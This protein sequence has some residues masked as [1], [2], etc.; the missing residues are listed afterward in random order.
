[1]KVFNLPDLG[2][3]L[4]EAEVVE[5]QVAEGEHVT[6][7][8]I[9]LAV[10]TAK[11]IV[12]I[13]SPQTGRV[14]KLL[15]KTGDLVKTGSA[16]LVYAESLEEDCLQANKNDQ[17]AIVGDLPHA[18]LS[19]QDNF[20]VTSQ[21]AYT[22][23]NSY[24]DHSV[25]ALA[26]HLNIDISTVKA[27]ADQLD[28]KDILQ[29]HQQ[30]NQFGKPEKLSGVRRSM[31][32]NMARVHQEVPQ[33]SLLDDADI[34]H[35]SDS[36]DMSLRL[37]KALQAGCEAV[38]DMNAW[39]QHTTQS[40][41]LLRQIDVGVAVDSPQGLFVP[42]MRDIA[43]RSQ[44][45]LRQ[46]LNQ[47]KQAVH[48]RTIPAQEMQGATIML[49]NFGNLGGRYATP[50]LMPPCVAIL[51]AGKIQRDAIAVDEHIC[52][53]RRLPL[54]LSFDHRVVTGAEASRFLLAVINSLQ[55]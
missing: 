22:P 38:P 17:G 1:M 10:E 44:E 49:S 54:S 12:D 25:Q 46:G 8:Q 11:A 35:W 4:P 13:P 40:R 51:G 26:Q 29:A 28:S 55:H 42:V 48:Q 20:I 45:D 14:E 7:D 21:H 53:H 27:S 19:T 43:S 30:H 32:M 9:I 33:V 5:W 16:L 37:L 3:G 47:L 41:Q 50:M 39:Y 52:I 18:N 2:E 34:Q 36:E 6:V 24:L 23:R 15:V 31:A